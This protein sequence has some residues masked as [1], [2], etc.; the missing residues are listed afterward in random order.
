MV[1]TE[2]MKLISSTYFFSVL[3][4]SSSTFLLLNSL[5]PFSGSDVSVPG[6]V[7]VIV[8]SL[9]TETSLYE[10]KDPLGDGVSI[11]VPI[12]E[13]AETGEGGGGGL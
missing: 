13:T 10:P 9:E 4:N 8:V 3:I 12:G 5:L 7:T 2:I 1:I 11:G 6:D